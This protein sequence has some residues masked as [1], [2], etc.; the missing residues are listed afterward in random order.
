[1]SCNKFMF[2][3]RCLKIKIDILL[4]HFHKVASKFWLPTQD[5]SLDNDLEKW[6]GLSHVH[7][8]KKSAKNG[9]LNWKLVDSQRFI[10]GLDWMQKEKYEMEKN[11]Q[12]ENKDKTKKGQVIMNFLL[13]KLAKGVPHRIYI[14][15]GACGT[16]DIAKEL[17]QK[18]HQYVISVSAN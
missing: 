15:A 6:T 8:D 11:S 10:V 12:P 17:S 9:L 14:D 2:I 4:N 18:N 3:Y 7:I 1:M 13:S 5:L 16:Y